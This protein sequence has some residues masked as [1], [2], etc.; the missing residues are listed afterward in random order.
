MAKK[1]EPFRFN[2]LTKAELIRT[3]K[4]LSA[5]ETKLL[6][7]IAKL[8]RDNAELKLRHPTLGHAGHQISSDNEGIAMPKWPWEAGN[9]LP[10]P[11]EGGK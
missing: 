10:N 7:R 2:T 11:F 8:E 4:T 5:R 9:S 1:P 3:I 6:N